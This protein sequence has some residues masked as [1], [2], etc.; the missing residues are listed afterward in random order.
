MIRGKMMS[1]FVAENLTLS[2]VNILQL[3]RFFVKR[4]NPVF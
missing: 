4:L 3:S 1:G 2:T